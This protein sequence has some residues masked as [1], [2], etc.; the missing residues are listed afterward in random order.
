MP[1]KPL[2]LFIAP[3]T[4]SVA[5]EPF[6]HPDWIFETKL[7]G[8][9]AIAVI[10][11]TGKA[12][13]W[14]RNRLPLEQKF[15]TVRGTTE[16]MSLRSTILDGEIV[17]LDEEG[18][19]RFQLLQ[20]WQK[21]PTAPVVYVLFDLLWDNG[22]DLTGKSVIQRRE[23][24]Q[25][26]ITPVADLL[27]LT[28]LIDQVQGRWEK[29]TAGLERAV[30]LD[31][32]NPRIL[33]DLALNYWCLRRYRDYE[34]IL[35]RLVELVPDQPLFQFYKAASAFAEKA[36]L[37]GVRAAYEAIPSSAKNDPQ[38]TVFGIA[39]AVCAR[40]FAAAKEILSKSQSEEMSFFGAFVPREIEAL[41]LE[42]LQGNH[43]TVEQFG[44]AREQLNRKAAAEPTDPYWLAA[45]ALADVALGRK[46]QI[47][48]GAM[49]MRPISEDAVDGPLIATD[50][51]LVCA[52]ANQFDLAFEQ[53]NTVIQMPN[54]FLCYGDLKTNP[55]WDPLRKD[56]RFDKLLAELAPKD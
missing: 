19:P 6:N 25:E 47:Q 5:K 7:D 18:I 21:R 53:L 1:R 23:R 4:A 10:D 43:P 48:E 37:I 29:A 11:S 31:P 52:W 3:I 39:Y 26:I 28:A 44:A 16:E 22:R 46:E 56:P 24:L 35:D 55:N 14:S 20:K 54:W 45:L 27:H 42:L 49:E 13:I 15:P 38:V 30:T 33:Y 12:R 32:R 8:Y 41:W 51:A 50:F 17:A 36:D 2:P 9:R 40:D 34:R